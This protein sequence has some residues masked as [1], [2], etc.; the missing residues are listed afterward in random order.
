MKDIKVILKEKI[1]IEIEK[2]KNEMYVLLKDMLETSSDY[3]STYIH[4]KS[5]LDVW[6]SCLTWLE[7]DDMDSLHKCLKSLI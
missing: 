2:T 4:L 3:P 6:Q 7:A 5:R 1:E